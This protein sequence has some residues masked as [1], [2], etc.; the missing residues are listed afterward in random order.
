MC[1]L[2]NITNAPETL[3]GFWFPDMSIEG[4]ERRLNILKDIVKQM[5]GT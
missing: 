2:N 4:V 5:E 1:K 3:Y